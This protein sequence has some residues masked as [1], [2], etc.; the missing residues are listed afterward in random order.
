MTGQ[1]ANARLRGWVAAAQAGLY[2][3]P[4]PEAVWAAHADDLIAEAKAAGFK[5]HQLTNRVP[6]GPGFEQWRTAFLESPRY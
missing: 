3:E 5:P 4:T 6:S 2:G 1:Y